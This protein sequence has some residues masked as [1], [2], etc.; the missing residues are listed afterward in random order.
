M[1]L[2]HRKVALVALVL[3]SVAVAIPAEEPVPAAGNPLPAEPPVAK[4][5][6]NTAGEVT[7]ETIPAA[8]LLALQMTGSFDQH[9]A[10]LGRIVQ[11]GMTAGVMRGAPFGLY[12]DDPGKVPADSLRWD[13]CIPVPPETKAEAPY[14]RLT[15]P[16]AEA[17][18]VTCKG[19]Y[20]GTAPCY[21]ALRAW[22][23]KN[24]YALAG[25]VQEHWLSD[26]SV[27]PEKVES[28][29]VF[30]VKKAPVKKP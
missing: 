10:A 1:I 15:L 20:Q 25:P 27:P 16:A 17:A 24:G 18:V 14:V 8:T 21:G 22:L 3:A 12:Y 23:E 7:L 5:S 28:K 30:P 13:V 11:Y 2:S 4:P 6:A 26:P 19:P 9:G 29:I